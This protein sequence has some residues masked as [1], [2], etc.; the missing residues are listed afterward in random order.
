M[1]RIQ[2]SEII[3]NIEDKN[4]NAFVG[5]PGELGSPQ[6]RKVKIPQM[7]AKMWVEGLFITCSWEYEFQLLWK[8][9]RTCL[10]N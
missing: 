8:S 7:L 4:M 3:L 2:H 1:G 10:K 9:V 6:A 5:G